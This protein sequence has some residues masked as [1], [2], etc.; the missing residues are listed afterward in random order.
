MMVSNKPGKVYKEMRES[1]FRRI[2]KTEA[3]KGAREDT[4]R[5]E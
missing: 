5:G 4:S 1:V 3:G 2:P